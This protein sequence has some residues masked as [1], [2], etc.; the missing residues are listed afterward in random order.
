MTTAPND[1]PDDLEGPAGAAWWPEHVKHWARK[2]FA[3]NGIVRPM[4]LLLCK[5]NPKTGLSF[6]KPMP[7]PIGIANMSTEDAKQAAS[8]AV[9]KAAAK[10]RA[11]GAAFLSESWMLRA[12]LAGGRKAEEAYREYMR[13]WRG[14]LEEHPDRLEVVTITWQHR[15]GG[16]SIWLAEIIREPGMKPFLADWMP[17]YA[18]SQAAGR[19][20]DLL[21]R[22]DT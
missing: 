2:F 17:Q 8:D 7:V 6:P 20:F 18:G 14:R 12:S 11:F 13:S 21:P 9:R 10:G 1:F 5:R 16:G 4:A 19:F 15:A 3:D 22:E